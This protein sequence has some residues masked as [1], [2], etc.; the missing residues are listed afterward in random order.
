MNGPLPSYILFDLDG[1]LLDS[2]P[3]IVFPYKRPADG[4]IAAAEDQSAEPSR[5]AH[6]DHPFAGGG[7]RRSSADGSVGAS[8]SEQLRHRGV[9]QDFML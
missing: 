4:W 3:G 5:T 9:A 7:E 2:L 8:L 1:T 6:Q